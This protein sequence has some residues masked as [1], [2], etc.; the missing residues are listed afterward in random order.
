M[1]RELDIKGDELDGGTTGNK[2]KV[3]IVVS[4]TR[5]ASKLTSVIFM[6]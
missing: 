5:S 3:S 6:G 4:S 2:E 1:R